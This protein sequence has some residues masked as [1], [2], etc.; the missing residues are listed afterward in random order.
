[1]KT[2]IVYYSRYGNSRVAAKLIA[3]QLNAPLHRIEVKKRKNVMTSTFTSLFGRRPKIKTIQLDPESWDFMVIVGPVWSGRPAAPLKTF[4]AETRLAEKK[5]AVF[6]THTK[7]DIHKRP[8]R[9]MKK[10]LDH[11]GARLVAVSGYNIGTKQHTVLKQRV[12]DLLSQ[13]PPQVIPS[14]DWVSNRKRNK[15]SSL[16]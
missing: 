3:K 9:W 6:F 11:F 16:K 1:M 5:I 14:A 4:L 2:V 8:T 15:K 10:V 7:T 12:W 13:L